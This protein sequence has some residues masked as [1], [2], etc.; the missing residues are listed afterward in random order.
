MPS[1]DKPFDGTEIPPLED[2]EL[3]SIPPVPETWSDDDETLYS[4]IDSIDSIATIDMAV[5]RP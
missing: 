5:E 2:V 3:A 1:W 4:L